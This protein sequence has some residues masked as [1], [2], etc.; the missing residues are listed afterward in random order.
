V[1][2]KAVEWRPFAHGQNIPHMARHDLRIWERFIDRYA[3]YFEEAAYDLAFGGAEITDPEA[4]EQERLMWRFNTAKRVDAVVRNPDEIWLCEVRPGSG[5]SAVGAVLGYTLL[6]EL[7]KWAD[8]PIVPTIVT[9]HTDQDTHTV[10]QHF[11]IQLIE[12]PEPDP[13]EPIRVG[14]RR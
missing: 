14:G 8:R 11:E 12:L 5:L 9:D 4:S 3:G 2:V 13:G 7:E 10:C 6:A 1:P